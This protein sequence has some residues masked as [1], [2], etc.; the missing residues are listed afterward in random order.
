MVEGGSALVVEDSGSMGAR[1]PE[2][3]DQDLGWRGGRRQVRDWAVGFIVS[4]G[5]LQV[6]NADETSKML[7]ARMS[8]ALVTLSFLGDA[9]V[10]LNT[11]QVHAR[12]AQKKV[13]YVL[14]HLKH[15]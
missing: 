14:I 11:Y 2:G 10:N 15:I 12:T 5:I 3:R 4:R 7:Y 13:Q 8:D 6:A 9:L 1:I